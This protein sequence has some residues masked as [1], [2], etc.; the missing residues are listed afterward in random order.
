MYVSPKPVKFLKL[1]NGREPFIEWLCSLRDDRAADRVK[2]RIARLRL[3]NFGD[4]RSVG[5]GILELRIDYGP[6]YR[7][8]GT[9]SRDFVVLL[10]GGTKSTQYED[11]KKAQTLKRSYLEI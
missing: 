1:P 6:G 2:A 11:I 5:G 4:L 8:Y 7:V 3:G 10:C 9:V